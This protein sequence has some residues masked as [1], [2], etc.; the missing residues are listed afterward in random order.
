MAEVKVAVEVRLRFVRPVIWAFRVIA[1]IHAL[2]LP[3]GV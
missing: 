1:R 2:R 3:Q